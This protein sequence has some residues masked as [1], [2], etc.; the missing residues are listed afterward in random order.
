MRGI[1]AAFMFL[2]TLPFPSMWQINK[3]D[4]ANSVIFFPFVGLVVGTICAFAYS[5]MGSFSTGLMQAAVYLLFM[6]LIT[7]ALHID[8]LG[9]TFDGI[10]SFRPKER[11]LE[12]MKDSSIGTYGAVAIIIDLMIRFSIVQSMNSK[13]AF[14]S[15]ILAPVTAKA[16]IGL[17]I[18]VSRDA[19]EGTGMGSMFMTYGKEKRA[20]IAMILGLLIVVCSLKIIFISAFIL[21]IFPA[22]AFRGL[23][24]K[25]IS[26][27]TGDTMGAANEI[28]EIS[29]MVFVI[30]ISKSFTM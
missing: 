4:F 12:I 26:G 3:K 29:F 15:I 7:G 24:Y 13:L 20:I 5:F 27:M 10:C 23:V 19:R 25:K 16:Y 11:M 18:G 30:I 2:T 21:C 8:G 6:C 1:V 17:L 28:I 14:I 22:V 9:D